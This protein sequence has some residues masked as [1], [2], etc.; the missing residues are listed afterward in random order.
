MA[1]DVGKGVALQGIGPPMGQSAALVKNHLSW[2][3]DN[4]VAAIIIIVDYQRPVLIYLLININNCANDMG[5]QP[6][7]VTLEHRTPM[8]NANTIDM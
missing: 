5:L 4:L 3:K 7:L 2:L 1:E 8:I 6:V